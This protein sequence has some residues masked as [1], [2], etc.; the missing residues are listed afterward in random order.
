M[1]WSVSPAQRTVSIPVVVTVGIALTAM[2]FDAELDTQPLEVTVTEYKPELATVALG[3][4]TRAD[5][6]VKPFG[7]LQVNVAPEAAEAAVN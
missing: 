5:V 2:F 7:P 6:E 1:S 3:M 4:L